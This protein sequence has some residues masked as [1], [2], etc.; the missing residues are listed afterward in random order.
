MN[1][2]N[3]CGAY[4]EHIQA[5]HHRLNLAL[6]EIRHQLEG[7]RDSTQPRTATD[8]VIDKLVGL[9]KELRGHFAEEE[10]GG[11]LE[12]AQVRCQSVGPNVV[13]L[14]NEHPQLAQELERLIAAMK[15]RTISEEE[16]RQRF[17]AFAT[18]LKA[19]E[20]NENRLVQYAFGGD[21]SDYDVEGDD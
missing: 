5:E 11:C 20:C 15:G 16:G 18:K 6:V 21:E 2:L 3:Q 10:K 9:L 1:T 13:A 4:L 14:M 19:H 17:E 12:E 8:A 7:L